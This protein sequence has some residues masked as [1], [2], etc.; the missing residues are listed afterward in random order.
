MKT[1]HGRQKSICG[2]LLPFVIIMVATCYSL[3]FVDIRLY[4]YSEVCVDGLYL[5]HMIRS[6]TNCLED[7][8]IDY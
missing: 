7:V 5:N 1:S 2:Y 4:Y 3:P 8:G 6:Y